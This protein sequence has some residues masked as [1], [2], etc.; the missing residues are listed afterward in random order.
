M[1]TR[2]D[3]RTVQSSARFKEVFK[4][5]N[6]FNQEKSWPMRTAYIPLSFLPRSMKYKARRQG[7]ETGEGNGVI[8]ILFEGG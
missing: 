8:C 7:R 6:V 2:S 3:I 5:G 1:V 4:V